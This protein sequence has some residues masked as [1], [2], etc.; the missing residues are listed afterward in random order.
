MQ[1]TGDLL[2]AYPIFQLVILQLSVPPLMMFLIGKVDIEMVI[3]KIF[4]QI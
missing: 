4:L 3:P 2:V 1:C